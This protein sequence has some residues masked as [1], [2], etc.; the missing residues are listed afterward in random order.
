M[1]SAHHVQKPCGSSIIYAH[2]SEFQPF[3]DSMVATYPSCSFPTP[4]LALVVFRYPSCT[5]P[6]TRH[7]GGRGMPQQAMR[8]FA[9]GIFVTATLCS[10]L[11]IV[12][13]QLQ[14]PNFA[15]AAL[16]LVH[17]APAWHGDGRNY[18]VCDATA[19]CLKPPGK[20]P[21]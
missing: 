9:P 5:N 8:I 14:R 10:R 1:S 12:R 20:T 13:R 6:T 21:G 11:A 15:S 17:S 19:T 7:R 3:S 4:P 18:V 16:R 2:Q